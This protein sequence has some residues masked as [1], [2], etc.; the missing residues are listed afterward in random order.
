MSPEQAQGQP[1]DVAIPSD[2]CDASAQR[3]RAAT[4]PPASLAWE[5]ETIDPGGQGKLS[6][7]KQHTLESQNVRFYVH[8]V[9][10][11]IFILY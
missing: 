1:A 7:A 8:I 6:K 10:W 5:P 2:A 9:F 4:P 11:A 3:E